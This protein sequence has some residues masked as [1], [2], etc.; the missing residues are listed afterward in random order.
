MSDLSNTS[1]VTQRR[2]FICVYAGGIF[3]DLGITEETVTRN[4][5]M[6]TS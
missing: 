5:Y 1:S 6:Y 4:V 2:E 3:E